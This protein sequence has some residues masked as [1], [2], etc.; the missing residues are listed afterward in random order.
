LKT[1]ALY[2][3]RFAVAALL[4]VGS[5][6]AS[7]QILIPSQT[8][9]MG[10]LNSSYPPYLTVNWESG[11]KN[12]GLVQFDLS[13]I[14]GPVTSANLSLYHLY[15]S[16]PGAQF[17]LFLNTSAW[18]PASVTS[19]AQLPTTASSPFAQLNIGASDYQTGLWRSVDITSMVDQWVLGTLPN[20]GFTLERLD[21]DNPF[22][23]FASGVN[24]LEH[25]PQLTVN[26]SA[27]VPDTATTSL[28]L[29]IGLL[30][31]GALRRLLRVR[32]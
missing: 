25:A 26:A 8:Q 17:G 28:L 2:L 13:S 10:I 4:A 27:S 20:Y 9:N 22:V 15:N 31:L 1:L 30:G 12:V 6:I 23:Y 16:Q 29:G 21:Q 18:S 24:D 19:W 11:E 32:A 14:A 7:A 5:S 3:R